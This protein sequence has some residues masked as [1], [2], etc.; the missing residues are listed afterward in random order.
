MS[1]DSNRIGL[2]ETIAALR[3]ELIASIDASKGEELQFQV[4]QVMVEFNVEVESNVELGGGIKFWVVELSG[5]EGVKDKVIHKVTIPLTPVRS[6][7]GSVYTKAGV[8]PN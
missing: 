7:G 2:K 8:I 6:D 1:K 3:K 5:K 4:G